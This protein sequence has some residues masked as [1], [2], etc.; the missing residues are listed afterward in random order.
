MRRYTKIT[1]AWSLL[2]ALLCAV[3]FVS[4]QS[5]QTTSYGNEN[6]V[7]LQIAGD[8][9]KLS[10]DENGVVKVEVFIDDYEP[11]TAS[12]NNNK[13]HATS[14]KYTYKVSPGTH[15]VKVV[16]KGEVLYNANIFASANQTKII[17]I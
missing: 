15:A 13:K 11:F 12:V 17:E 14:Y 10:K 4:C 3:F 16:Y 2:I 7:Y 8:T 9:A 5:A 6:A 1:T